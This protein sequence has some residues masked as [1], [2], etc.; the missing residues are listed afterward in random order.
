MEHHQEEGLQE[1]PPREIEGPQ[2]TRYFGLTDI[3]GWPGN[4]REHDEDAIQQSIDRFG[5]KGH[6]M[7]DVRSNR[8]VRGHG[9]I[10]ILRRKKTAGEAPPEGVIEFLGEW[11]VPVEMESFNSDAE[12]EAFLLADNRVGQRGGWLRDELEAMVQ[13]VEQATG[14]LAGTGFTSDGLESLFVDAAAAAAAVAG[15]GGLYGRPSAEAKRKLAD[16]FGVPPF[17][18][19]DTR[20]GYWQDR[21]RAWL[22][23]GIRSERGRGDNLLTSGGAWIG[24]GTS[25]FDPVLAEL[26]YRWFCPPAGTIL[27]PFAGGSVRGVVAAHL[28]RPYTGVDLRPEQVAANAAQWSEIGGEAGQVAAAPRW[29]AGDSMNLPELAGGTEYDFV[30]TCP[31]YADLEVYSDDPADLSNMPYAAFRAA[32]S[33]IIGHAAQLLRPD[34]F[35]AIVVGEVRDPEGIYR[36]FVGDTV[37]ACLGA[38]L[39]FYNECSVVTPAGSLPVRVGRQFERSRKLGK[40]HQNL[41]VFVKGDPEAATAAVGPVEFGEGGADVMEDPATARAA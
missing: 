6:V 24:S 27:D 20:Q 35:F 10:K 30:F 12:A 33:A 21:K 13:R 41:L 2:R 38:G 36:N 29:V 31:P 7:M 4:P 37:T 22:D 3:E 39:R 5:F 25:V 17:T 8:L 9:R 11:F 26:A 16:R 28:G 34:R 32:Y 18:V 23:L 40:T 15:R 14:T 19:L 1:T